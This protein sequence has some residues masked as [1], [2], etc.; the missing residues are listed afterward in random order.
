MKHVKTRNRVVREV[1]DKHT[2]NIRVLFS[3]VFLIVITFTVSA[4][5][6]VWQWAVPVR[7]FAKQPKNPDAKAYLWIP[8]KCKHVKA[9]LVAQ[10]NMEEISIMEDENFRIKMAELDVAQIW[11]CPSFNHGFDFRGFSERSGVSF[12]IYGVGIGS[13]DWYRTFGS[14]QLALLFSCIYARPYISLYLSQWTVAL[15]T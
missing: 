10:H 7:N 13:I 8:E 5:T 3:L 2:M 9:V 6:A 1:S 4:Q 12:R 15:C 14:C 11:V